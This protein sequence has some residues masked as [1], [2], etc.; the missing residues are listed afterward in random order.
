[1]SS[2]ALKSGIVWNGDAALGTPG[3]FEEARL[4]EIDQF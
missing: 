2:G 4:G 1:L 3:L